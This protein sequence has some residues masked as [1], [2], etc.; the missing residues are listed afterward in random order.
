MGWLRSIFA[1]QEEAKRL[2]KERDF[3]R[4]QLDIIGDNYDKL[5]A[6]LFTEIN[7]NRRIV[8]TLTHELLAQAA[9]QMRLPFRDDLEIT[10][11]A[12][13]EIEPI[14]VETRD[15]SMEDAVE[16]RAKEFEEQSPIP[17][18]EGDR[19]LLREKIRRDPE[20]FTN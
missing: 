17:Y 1:A 14:E 13:T 6:K 2:R 16:A 15:V 19:I 4:E 10:A 12:D 7:S 11:T 18:T 9:P 8:D 5:E 20:M 3:Y